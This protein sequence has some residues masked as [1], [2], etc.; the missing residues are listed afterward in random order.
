MSKLLQNTMIKLDGTT[1]K[2]AKK[3]AEDTKK[4]IV[5]ELHE[6]T[7][8]SKIRLKSHKTIVSKLH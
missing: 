6:T 8:N 1:R 3:L 4:T 5:I 2:K 7:I